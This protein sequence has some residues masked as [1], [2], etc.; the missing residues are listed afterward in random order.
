MAW[1]KRPYAVGLVVVATGLVAFVFMRFHSVTY[2]RVTVVQDNLTREHS[3]CFGGDDH[4]CPP[5]IWGYRMI[6][7][8]DGQE[9]DFEQERQLYFYEGESLPEV[10]ERICVEIPNSLGR[11]SQRDGNEA[12]TRWVSSWLCG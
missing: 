5:A 8:S 2:Q 10:G 9:R 7:F 3:A 6:K 1:L 4:V 11:V 12:R